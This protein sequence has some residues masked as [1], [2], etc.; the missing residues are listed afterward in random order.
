M[1]WYTRFFASILSQLFIVCCVATGSSEHWSKVSGFHCTTLIQAAT[2]LA[3]A[4]HLR[5]NTISLSEE[6]ESGPWRNILIV[7]SA[8]IWFTLM[9]IVCHTM[10]GF[11][12]FVHATIQVSS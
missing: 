4:I 6:V 8:L 9:G 5:S 1:S 3:S 12:V 7:N 2:L 11:S 10:K